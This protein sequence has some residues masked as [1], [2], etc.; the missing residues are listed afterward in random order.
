MLDFISTVIAIVM[1]CA[2]AVIMW[3]KDWWG[4]IISVIC[5]GSAVYG[6]FT[7]FWIL[8]IVVIVAIA[9][10]VSQK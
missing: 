2:I 1:L 10:G 5:A 4:K 6:I 7:S 8:I 3:K 9:V